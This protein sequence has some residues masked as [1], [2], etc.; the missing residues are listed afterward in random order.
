M[1]LSLLSPVT[2]ILHKLEEALII[3]NRSENE[4]INLIETLKKKLISILP[5]MISSTNEQIM[6]KIIN[7]FIV[8]KNIY[9]E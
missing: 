4:T 3:T 9:F 8:T 7:I 5:F 1:L 2:N 6:K